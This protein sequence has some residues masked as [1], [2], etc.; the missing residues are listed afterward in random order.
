MAE[1]ITVRKN[2]TQDF[3]VPLFEADGTTELILAATDEVRI[4]FFKR[5]GDTPA[6]DLD[7][8]GATGNGS[9]ITIDTLNPA[10]CTLRI[11][12]G[13]TSALEPG[14]YRGDVDVVDDSETAPANAIKHAE[15]ILL[16]LLESG[17]GDVGLT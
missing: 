16:F 11:A 5:D 13:D 4:K 2:R 17:G 9:V 7:S 3:T 12:Q 8:I 15:S 1:T 10:S 14:A 6:L